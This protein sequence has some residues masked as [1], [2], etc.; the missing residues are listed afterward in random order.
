MS[1]EEKSLIEENKEQYNM[2]LNRLERAVGLV[3]LGAS[4][5]WSLD[6]RATYCLRLVGSGGVVSLENPGTVRRAITILENAR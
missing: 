2:L 1:S 6:K 3:N 5:S 4:K